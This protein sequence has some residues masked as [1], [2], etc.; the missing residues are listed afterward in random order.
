[1]HYLSPLEKLYHWEQQIPEKVYLRQPIEGKWIEFSWKQSAEE[2]RKM[3]AYLKS[4]HLPAGSK[5]GIF[6]KNCAHWIMADLA[7]MMAGYVSI[8]LYPN[9]SAGSINQILLHSETSVLFVGKLDGFESMKA[10]IPPTI[11]CISFPYYEH[12][13]YVN[14]NDLVKGIEP[15]KENV[16]RLPQELATIIYTSG[17]TGIP[18]GVMHNFHSFAFACTHA[19][20]LAGVGSESRFFSYLPLSHIAERL[21]VEM[22]SIYSGGTVSFVESIET[23]SRNLRDTEPTVFLAVPRIWAKL[24]EEIFKKIP[25]SILNLLLAIPVVST[26]VKR[27]IKQTL[28]LHKA[29]NIFTGAAPTPVSLLEWFKKLDLHIQEAYAM[30]ENCCYSHVTLNNQIKIGYVGKALPHCDVKLSATS[31]ILIKHEASMLGYYKEEGQTKEV[32]TEDGYFKTGDIGEIDSEGYLKITGRVKDIFKS[33]KGKYIAPLPIELKLM[34]HLLIEQV[35]V[36]GEGLAQ[37]MALIVL[38][39]GAK[40]YDQPYISNELGNFLFMINN[41]LDQHEIIHKIV[42]VKENWSMENGFLT[43]TLKIKRLIIEK[44]YAK[45]YNQWFALSLNV[46]WQ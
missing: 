4:L 18:K 38:S 13:E 30:T 19:L 21:L 43:P 3:A 15:L 42:I 24:Q 46:I 36:V 17:T 7:I 20:E 26:L 34:S 45:F 11:K 33:S 39:A 32:F 29:T 22:G 27:R 9:L 10:G 6:S 2:V 44:Q 16:I 37:P 14:W 8:P 1:M 23:F 12:Q 28:G 40:K 31:E 5:I 25:Q 35:C 41:S